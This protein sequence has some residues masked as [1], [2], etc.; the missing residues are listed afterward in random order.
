MSSESVPRGRPFV[1][2]NG[3]RRPGSK[4]KS[5]LLAEALL[6]GEGADLVRTAIEL[7]KDGNVPMLKFVLER[8]LPKERPVKLDVPQ[9]DHPHEAGQ[10]LAA[11][12]RA[13]AAGEITPSEGSAV[14]AL[15]GG[16]PR[17][18]NITEFENRVQELEFANK[19]L[20]AK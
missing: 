12:L 9:I 20:S 4:N 7:A 18:V 14:A 11:V 15:V 2:G 10:V 17:F 13:V 1:K 6:P 5:T 8:I 16:F 19:E 3:G